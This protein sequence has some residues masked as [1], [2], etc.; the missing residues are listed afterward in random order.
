MNRMIEG[1]ADIGRRQ[2]SATKSNNNN[3][4]ER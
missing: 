4:Y 3:I 1:Q 2:I